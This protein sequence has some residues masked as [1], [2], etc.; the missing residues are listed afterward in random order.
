MDEKNRVHG[1]IDTSAPPMVG[2]GPLQAY[3]VADCPE[4]GFLQI[5]NGENPMAQAI[6]GVKIPKGAMLLLTTVE[7]ATF[8][9]T[10]FAKAKSEQERAYAKTML[11]EV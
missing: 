5:V 8:L 11:R 1:P 2:V 3:S 10:M 7:A 4:G 6:P 9:R